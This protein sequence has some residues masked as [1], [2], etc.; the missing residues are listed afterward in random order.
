M[1]AS[2]NFLSTKIANKETLQKN[3]IGTNTSFLP[4]FN[5]VK[6]QIGWKWVNKKR[7]IRTKTDKG[8]W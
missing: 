6:P 4:L 8:F 7:K 1:R 3:G 5:T 2:F